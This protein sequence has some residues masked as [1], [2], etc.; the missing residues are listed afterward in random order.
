MCVFCK[1]IKGEISS[2]KIYE[3]NDVY[4]FLDIGDD[5]IG[6][7]L[8]V[9]KYH[10]ENLLDVPNELMHKVM[11]V[12]KMISNHYVNNCGFTGV[13]ILNNSGKDADQSV[14]HLHIH[15]MPRKEGDGIKV[16]DLKARM[17]S[18]FEE[19]CE[20]LRIK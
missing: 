5:V 6:H 8:V 1:I 12:A 3:D 20:K 7:T 18:N 19:V 17:G 4:A 15:I 10:Y 9:P 11:D 16:Y 13:N 2:Y 14:F